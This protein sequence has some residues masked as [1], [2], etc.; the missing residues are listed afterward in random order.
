MS[1]P[2]AE[3]LDTWLS[4][5]IDAAAL[6]WLHER[7]QAT[8]RSGADA[9]FFLSFG[10]V[11]R[12]IGRDALAPRS[13]ELHAAARA[14][15]GWDPS[16]WTR[17][18]AARTLLL[19][20]LPSADEATYTAALGRVL[21]DAD[22]GELVAITQA[23]PLLPHPALHRERAA[24]A[25]RS[26]MLPVFQAIALDNPYAAEQL[27]E[28]AWAQLVLKCL[29]VES[30]LHRVQGLDSRVTPGLA[31][32]LSDYAHERW[33]ASRPVSPEVWRCVG[34]VAEGSLLADLER[35]I[36]T[37]SDR[38]RA[39][40]GLAIRDNPACQAL[41]DTHAVVLEDALS[42][43]PGWDALFAT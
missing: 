22:L 7:V 11:P 24:E 34:P 21:C 29:F 15:P 18:Q 23:L 14:R 39:A 1:V 42:R 28:G 12:K 17:D 5:R 30:P 32:M 41:R 43:F 20:A 40:V 2:P 3:L 25:I 8:L 4:T 37:G 38:E 31:R 35:V 16:R 27:A 19:L 36:V 26:N 33:A 13:A 6:G 10:L 9:G